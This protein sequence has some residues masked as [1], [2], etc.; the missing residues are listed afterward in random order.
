MTVLY[1]GEGEQ[2]MNKIVPYKH[3]EKHNP[4]SLETA[5]SL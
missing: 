1:T 2:E 4:A 5:S 3:R